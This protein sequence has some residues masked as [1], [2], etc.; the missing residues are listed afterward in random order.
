MKFDIDYLHNF[1][2]IHEELGVGP[3]VRFD[4]TYNF[5]EFL[6]TLGVRSPYARNISEVV[7]TSMT[8]KYLH[9]HT[10][11]HPLYMFAIAAH[12]GFDLTEAEIL[13]V[14]CHDAIYRVGKGFSN[15]NN[16]AWFM[17]SLLDGLVL[18][19][20]IGEAFVIIGDTALHLSEDVKPLSHLVMDLDL[21]HLAAEEPVFSTTD[22]LVMK[23]F[24]EIFPAD[25]VNKGRLEFLQKMLSRPMI[26]RTVA[27]RNLFEV[28]AREN[29]SRALSRLKAV[30]KE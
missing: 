12:Y 23:E 22:T 30:V 17:N 11:V 8:H 29:L 15:E 2:D 7:W 5:M 26:Y 27:M 6:E 18:P 21:A 25:M 28:K 16:S 24:L 4:F 10:P 14:W 9:Y 20:K 13:A 1:W 19:Q 3:K